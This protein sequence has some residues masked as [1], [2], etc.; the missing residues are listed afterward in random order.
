MFIFSSKLLS[1]QRVYF[2]MV[3][4]VENYGKLTFDSGKNLPFIWQRCKTAKRPGIYMNLA[5]NNV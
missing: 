3:E 1:Y 2:L 4:M 5:N